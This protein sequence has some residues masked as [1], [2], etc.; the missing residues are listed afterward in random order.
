MITVVM[1]VLGH[2]KLTNNML[3][4][5]SN[6]IVKPEMVII[7]DNDYKSNLG[8][9][10]EKYRGEL[11]IC[12]IKNNTNIGVNPCW[13]EGILRSK[14]PLISILNNDLLI[15]KYFFKKIIETYNENDKYGI[16]CPNTIKNRA[17]VETT[18]DDK[19]IVNKMG[20]REGWA[21]TIR[22]DLTNK[23]DPIPEELKIYCG[24]DY[25]FKK[26]RDL[27]YKAV[28]IMNN[29]IYHFGGVTVSGH[30]GKRTPLKEEKVIWSDILKKE[31]SND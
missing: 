27:E 21:F 3:R 20:K 12:Y 17:T 19:V 28:K 29:Y 30:F 16:I 11:N 2:I 5:M 7:F 9:I 10:I 4:M 18:N 23:M 31:I 24:D 14:T 6:N 8:S 25:L 13:N 1:P 26:C 15:S 22:K